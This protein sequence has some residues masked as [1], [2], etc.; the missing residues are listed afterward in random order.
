[1]LEEAVARDQTSC[2]PVLLARLHDFLYVENVNATPARL[3]L[4]AHAA[5][6]ALAVE[7]DSGEAHLALAHHYFSA[8]HDYPRALAE[9]DLARRTLPNNAQVYGM[10]GT[11][12]RSQGRWEEAE[13]DLDAPSRSIPTTE[14]PTRP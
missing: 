11:I 10:A 12:K 14:R 1:M 8:L 9:V 6:Q 3:E 2:G 13:H 4:G 5:G 7:P